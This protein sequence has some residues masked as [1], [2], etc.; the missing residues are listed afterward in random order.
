VPAPP[1]P[2]FG[3][4]QV[5]ALVLPSTGWA[6]SVQHGRFQVLPVFTGLAEV[7]AF[8]ARARVPE[9]RVVKLATAGAVAD[10]LRSPPG[11]LGKAGEFLVAVD[12]DD[13]TNLAPVLFTV[14]ELIAAL[15][16]GSD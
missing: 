12:P 9:F 10:F 8:L 6:V 13:L 5:Y 15:A 2:M 7:E 16:G 1:D 11:R 3:F 4:P 14:R